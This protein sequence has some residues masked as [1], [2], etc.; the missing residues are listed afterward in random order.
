MQSL[1]EFSLQSTYYTVCANNLSFLFKV[2]WMR[3]VAYLRSDERKVVVVVDG[4]IDE[5]VG[6]W[7][8]VC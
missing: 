8:Y 2:A 4:S 5:I 3:E 7:Q 6:S 1:Q